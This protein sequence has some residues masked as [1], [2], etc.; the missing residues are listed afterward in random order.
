M[1]FQPRSNTDRIEQIRL[2]LASMIDIIFLLL[3]FF[4]VNTVFVLPESHLDPN[5]QTEQ[6]DAAAKA[7]DFTPQVLNLELVGRDPVYRLGMRVV[8]DRDELQSMLELLPK[9]LG[10]FVYVDDRVPV[11][12]CASAIQVCHNAGFEK[13]TYVPSEL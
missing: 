4:I 5:I 12:F 1:R 11:G 13:I 2:N 3:V 8:K 6:E 7:A 10:I 9:D